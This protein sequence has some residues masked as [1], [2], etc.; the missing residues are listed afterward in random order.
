MFNSYGQ[1]AND[2]NNSTYLRFIFEAF[3]KKF[4]SIVILNSISVFSGYFEL[5]CK[6]IILNLKKNGFLKNFE[7]TKKMDKPRPNTI[8]SKLFR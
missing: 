6:K 8:F 7:K 4:R 2:K 5:S 1:A 3:E